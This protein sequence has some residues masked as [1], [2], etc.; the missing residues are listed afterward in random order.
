MTVIQKPRRSRGLKSMRTAVVASAA[1]VGLVIGSGSASAAVDDSNS[2][3]DGGGNTITVSQ[4]DTFI[5]SVAPLDGNPLT[6]E[7]FHNGRAIVDVAGPDAADFEGDITLGYQFGY[8]GSMAG[9]LTFGYTTPNIS[10]EFGIDGDGVIPGA[11]L[12]TNDLL[13][14]AGGSIDLGY[15]PGIADVVVGEGSASGEHTEI[16]ISNVQGTATGILGNVTVRP[17]VKV[18]SGNGDSVTTYGQPWR[19]N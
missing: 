10:A 15:G 8:P 6:R 12:S 16:Q 17:Y 11:T 2:V 18:V 3:V 13:P 14:S 5:N 9:T 1:I 4:A 7:W 19:F